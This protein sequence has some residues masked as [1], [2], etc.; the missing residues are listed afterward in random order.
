MKIRDMKKII[1]AIAAFALVAGTI[2]CSE[3]LELDPD[4]RVTIEQVF[5]TYYRTNEYFNSCYNYVPQ[6]GLTYDGGS[7]ALAS[8]CDEAHDANDHKDGSVTGWYEGW[9][10][11]TYNP[12][13][14]GATDFWSNQFQGIRKCNS[15]LK[16]I[17]DPA[18]ATYDFNEEQKAGWIAQIRVL[19][20]YYYLMLIKCYGGVPI[21]DTPYEEDHDYSNDRRASFEECVDFII[22]ECDV[23]LATPLPATADYGFRWDRTGESMRS[24]MTR[25]VAQAIRSQA[26]LYAASPLHYTSGSK[27]TWEKVTQITK[28]ALEECLANGFE[29]YKANISPT[30][31]QNFYA[32][33]FFTRSDVERGWDKETIHDPNVLRTYI[34]RNAGVPITSGMNKA[35]PCPSQELV[36]AFETIDG[37]PILDLSNPYADA[38]RTVPNLNPANT[39]YD[40]NDPY[41][42]RDPR[43]Y[44]NIYYNGAQRYLDG[45]DPTLVE[46]Y[47]G[48]NCGISDRV[49]DVR[50]TRTGYYMRKFN[51]WRSNIG[52]TE[53]DG[54]MRRFRLAEL[55]LNFAEA[56]YNYAGPDAQIPAVAGGQPMSA[57]EAVN[58]IRARVDMPDIPAGLSTAEFELRY[59]NERRVELAFEEHRFFDVR[60]W[61]ILDRTDGF[62]TAM[63]ITKNSDDSFTYQRVKLSDRPTA[64]D[65][66][67]YFPIVQSEVNK[68]LM[69]TGDNWQ[70]PGW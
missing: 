14:A 48:G 53:R 44:A 24:Y 69:L 43:F 31:A 1:T 46:T 9:T 37:Q 41:A 25:G 15:F 61:K 20:A 8:F 63:R 4:G 19:R 67:L 11:S 26:A 28:E 30:D 36:D 68:M 39:V 47:V 58:V 38:D 6:I 21:I 42:N 62:V 45:S 29:L 35:G 49:T 40:P 10:S 51:D 57:R 56:A 34:Y 60:R 33:Y 22:A 64:Q 66:Y 16:Y 17:Q 13:T 3:M 50:Y 54:L 55:Y 18:I 2:S 32:Y 70:N 5:S 27:Y 12:L 23:A 7:T 65:K 52:D 59:R